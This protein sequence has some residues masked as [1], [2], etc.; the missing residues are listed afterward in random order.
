MEGSTA[1]KAWGAL[2]NSQQSARALGFSG[3]KQF[4]LQHP[5]VQ[6]MLQSLPEAAYCEAYA[7]WLE[8]VPSAP[9]LVR[10]S[11]TSA[12]AAALSFPTRLDTVS[13]K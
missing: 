13:Q 12:P 10:A 7:G 8:S 2:F 9:A 4:G 6:R 5:R 3:A 11:V 1:T